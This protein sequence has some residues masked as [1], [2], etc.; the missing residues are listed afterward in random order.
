[1]R[2]LAIATTMILAAAVLAVG[3]LSAQ[4]SGAKFRI[5][6]H[7]DTPETTLSRAEV[8]DLLLKKQ[9]K[10]QSGSA[11]KPVDLASGS[12]VRETFSLA[13]HGRSVDRVKNYWQR[14]IFS[15]REVPPP[16]LDSSQAVAEFVRRTPGS[17]GYVGD[18]V[19]TPAVNT[20]TLSD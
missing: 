14:R 13:V 2:Q 6:V 3:M 9:T 12:A 16:E 10:W 5:I 17:I 1:M 20:V 15:G 11:V 18:D 4:G 8:S 7:A 19:D